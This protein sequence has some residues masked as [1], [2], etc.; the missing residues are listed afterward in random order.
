VRRRIAID[1][2]L[3]MKDAYAALLREVIS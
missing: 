3:P 2:A 1:D